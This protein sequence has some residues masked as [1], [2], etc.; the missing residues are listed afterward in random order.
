MADSLA[1]LEGLPIEL[2]QRLLSLRDNTEEMRVNEQK[3]RKAARTPREVRVSVQQG[4]DRR[5][6]VQVTTVG[7]TVLLDLGA[8]VYPVLCA[9]MEKFQVSWENFFEQ[10]VQRG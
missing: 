6:R 5:T 7:E 1:I 4:E 3:R 8:E 10:V 9:Q 2:V